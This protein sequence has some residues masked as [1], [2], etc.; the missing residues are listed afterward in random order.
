MNIR[1]TLHIAKR[2]VQSFIFFFSYQAKIIKSDF[3]FLLIK[4]GLSQKKFNK[5]NLG[6]GSLLIKD[7]CNIDI[8]FKSDLIVDLEKKLLPFQDNS[9]DTAICISAIN[10]FTRQRGEEIIKETFRVLKPGGIARFATQDL[11]LIAEKYLNNDREFFFQK[12]ADGRERF[13]GATIGDK[14]NSWFYGYAVAKNKG[15]KYFYDFETL[16]LIFKEAGFSKIENKKYQESA[17]PDIAAIDNRPE[18]M[19]FLEAVK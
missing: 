9:I 8:Y 16:A 12:L 2:R 1:K 15:C 6:S 14:F 11:K 18:Q 19:F 10:Y 4:F 5:I 7:Y 3:K 13:V 17:I